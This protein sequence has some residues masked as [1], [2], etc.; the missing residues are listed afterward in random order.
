MQTEP[1]HVVI[2]GGG[3]GGL[4]AAKC[5]K[6]APVRVTLVDRRNGHLFQPCLSQVATGSLS[7][8][9]CVPTGAGGRRGAGAAAGL[10]PR[11]F[12]NGTVMTLTFVP[13]H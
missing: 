1:H 6:G 12:R 10:N 3:F 2:V 8:G 7:P 11:P 9:V 5:L 13:K 4:D